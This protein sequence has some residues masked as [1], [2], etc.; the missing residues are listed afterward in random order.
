MNDIIYTLSVDSSILRLFLLIMN[1]LSNIAL[2]TSE[3]LEIFTT[4]LSLTELPSYRAIYT[5]VSML[6]SKMKYS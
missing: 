4:Q 6:R 3:E 5:H 1:V 2:Q